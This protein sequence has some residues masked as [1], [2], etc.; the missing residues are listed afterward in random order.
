MTDQA[1]IPLVIP[2]RQRTSLPLAQLKTCSRS[3]V[4]TVVALAI[5]VRTAP[6]TLSPSPAAA[7][8]MTNARNLRSWVQAH[9]TRGAY[10]RLHWPTHLEVATARQ[11]LVL[12]RP[13]FVPGRVAVTSGPW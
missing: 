9:T 8:A 2:G 3:A 13:G 11:G 12:T 10:F 6:T 5:Q 4:L 7:L 1:V